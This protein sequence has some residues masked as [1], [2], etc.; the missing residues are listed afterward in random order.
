[1]MPKECITDKNVDAVLH[2]SR[3]VWILRVPRYFLDRVAEIL[4]AFQP[5]KRV[6][7]ATLIV[8]VGAT[9]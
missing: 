2:K 4:T 7:S 5:R 6:T 8:A 1:M 3:S 9:I